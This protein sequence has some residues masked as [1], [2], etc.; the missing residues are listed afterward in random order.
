MCGKNYDIEVEIAT[1]DGSKYVQEDMWK[2]GTCFDPF[3][4]ASQ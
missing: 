2:V 4:L 1:V 3:A